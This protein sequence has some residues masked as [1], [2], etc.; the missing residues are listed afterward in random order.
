MNVPPGARS[1]ATF[2]TP[3]AP[4]DEV[5]RYDFTVGACRL[6]TGFEDQTSCAARMTGEGPIRISGP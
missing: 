4:C 5:D 6:G 3:R 1:E 2:E